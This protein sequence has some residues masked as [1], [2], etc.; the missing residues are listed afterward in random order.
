MELPGYESFMAFT[1]DGLPDDST[2]LKSVERTIAGLQ[3]LKNAPVAD[4]YTGPAILSGRAG[5]TF[6]HEVFGHRVE[7]HQ[8]KNEVVSL[9]EYANEQGHALRSAC[10]RR[11][12]S[13]HNAITLGLSPTQKR[14]SKIL[15][16]MS[17]NEGVRRYASA[18]GAS[19]QSKWIVSEYAV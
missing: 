17:S 18:I 7:G 12:D 19:Y 5:G 15:L 6:F 14:R 9:R 3:A 16:A 8:Q 11:S 4:P 1:P 2:V 10:T 13:G